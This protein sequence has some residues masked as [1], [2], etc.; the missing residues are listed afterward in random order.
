V[1]ELKKYLVYNE[2]TSPPLG[3]HGASAMYVAKDVDAILAERDAEI[4]RL[5]AGAKQTSL[6]MELDDK[7]IKSV[8]AL[9]RRHGR[10]GGESIVDGVYALI[11]D[12]ARDASARDSYLVR[13]FW[14]PCRK[15]IAMVHVPFGTSDIAA[16][17]DDNGDQWEPIGETENMAEVKP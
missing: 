6:L 11:Q 9:L 4:E 17:T 14:S 12:A 13:S 15:Y 10:P 3:P 7:C 1:I 5:K 8:S 2:E 16:I